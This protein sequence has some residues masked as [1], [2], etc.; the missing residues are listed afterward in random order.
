MLDAAAAS[1]RAMLLAPFVPFS[2]HATAAMP[3][4]YI[5]AIKRAHATTTLILIRLMLMMSR[6]HFNVIIFIDD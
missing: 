4:R 3:P 5:F 2:S 6:K 1:V